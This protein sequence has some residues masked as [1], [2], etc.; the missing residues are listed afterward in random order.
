[1]FPNIIHRKKSRSERFDIALVEGGML[2]AIRLNFLV[3]LEEVIFENVYTE[4]LNIYII[5]RNDRN[6]KKL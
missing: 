3:Y 1:M 5:L 4:V 2:H 6:G